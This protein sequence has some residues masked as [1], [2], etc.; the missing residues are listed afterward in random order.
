M[1]TYDLNA[2]V[3]APTLDEYIWDRS[4]CSFIMGPLGSGK[5]YASIVRI[6]QLMIEQEPNGRGERPSRFVAVRNTYPDLTTT[7]IK[8]FQEIFTPQL[9]TMK[10]G[11]VEPPT[12]TVNAML[13]DGT[14]IRSEV[15]FLAL[16]RSDAVK[17]LRGVQA[18]AFWLNESKELAKPIIDMADLRHGRYPS[19]AAGGVECTWHGMFGDTNAPDEDSWYF[20]LAEQVQPEGWRFFRQPGGLIPTGEKRADGTEIFEPNSDADNLENLPEGYYKRGQGGKADDWIRVNLCNEYGFLVDGRPVHPEYVD[21]VHCAPDT[22]P[23]DSS[24]PLILGIDFGRTPAAA[25]FQFQPQWGRFVA[26]DEFVSEDMSQQLFAP[27]LRVWLNTNFQVDFD[28]PEGV[29]KKVR[30][31]SD[32]AGDAKGQATEDTPRLILVA[33][34]VPTLPAPSNSPT[35]R[36]AALA[37]PMRRLCM[38][39]KPAFQISPKCKMLRKGLMGGFCYRKLKIPGEDRFHQAP[40]KNIY[41]H[42]VESAEYALLS[43]GEGV[44]ALTVSE[45]DAYDEGPL[46][47]YAL[48]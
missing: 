20:K 27:E 15:I 34:G 42:I 24:L 37:N 41:S 47:E 17:K 31:W 32:P 16:D 9:G 1:A 21:S 46:Q 29:K 48:F 40:D 25:V 23:Y 36:R 13:P 8:D 33:N 6:M 19:R 2:G 3:F 38:D 39:G 4:R 35:L 18:T 26:I 30:A 11:G 43:E 14:K 44:A 10:M 12:F 28:N 45:D 7:T 22:I 5:T